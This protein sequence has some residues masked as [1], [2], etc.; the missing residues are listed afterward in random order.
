MRYVA[1]AGAPIR[2]SDLARW[3]MVLAS[4]PDPAATLEQ[5]IRDRFGVRRSFLTSTGRAGMTVLLRAMKQLSPSRDE[6]VLPSYT[7]YSVAASVIKAGL[8]P[9][10]VDVAPETLDYASGQLERADFTRVLA[11]IATN[12]YGLPNDLPRIAAVAKRQGAFVIDDAAQALGAKVGGHWSGTCGDA[13]LF[14]LDKGKN[15]SAID[16]GI[17]VTSSDAIAG[18][19]AV[20]ME[21]LPVPGV[22]HAGTAVAKAVAY[23]VL[24]RPWLYG[25]PNS[26]PQLGLGKTVFTTDFPLERPARALVS[27]GVTMLDRLEDFTRV[28]VANANA[29]RA[30]LSGLDGVQLVS[31]ASSADPVYLRLPVLVADAG[32]RDRLIAKL[33]AAGIG[34]TG[35]YPASLADVRELQPFV[36]GSAAAGGRFIARHVITLPTHAFVSAADIDRTIR[37]LADATAA[38]SRKST[39]A[40]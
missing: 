1:P 13:G 40:A 4:T 28:R 36:A 29:L 37:I 32:V 33:N 9:R 15:V 3:A 6:V 31:P 39:P 25:I 38:A 8:R 23:A 24:L 19:M 27:L 30:G 35:S 21:R 10:I 14:S 20:E 12:L 18:A 34:A 26:I 16:G 11:V 5:G 22:A 7:C 17:V 2:L